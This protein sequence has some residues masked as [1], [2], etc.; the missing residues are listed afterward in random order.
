[1]S[2]SYTE[3]TSKN[4]FSRIAESIKGILF[5]VIVIPL[6]IFVLWWNE[7]RAVTT[8]K[9]LKEGAAAVVDVSPDQ[10]DPANDKK[11]VH[12]TGD[13]EAAEPVI[14][15]EFGISVPALRLVRSEEIFQWVEDTHTETKEKVGGSEETRTTYTYE[16]EW[17]D[18][19]VRSTK[20]KKPL[21][22]ENRGSLIAG[23]AN[24]S[25]EK[26]M[27]G[28]F[29]VPES[30]VREM[31][32]PTKH[33]VTDEDLKGL[34]ADLRDRAQIHAGT[35]YFGDDPDNPVIGD[36]RVSFQVVKPG[37]FSILAAQVGGTFGPYQTK[38]GDALTRVESGAVTAEV[39]FRNAESENT[40]MTW[41]ARL[42]GFLFMSF[43]F[44]AI[45][46]P[47]SVLGSVVPFIGS[48]IGMGTGLISFVLAGIISL[49]VIAI[50]WVVARPLLGIALLVLAVGGVIYMRKLAAASKAAA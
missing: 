38:A 26:V 12:V 20:F 28:A 31:G 40:F 43:G 32:D 17:T 48:I 1:M 46:R 24:I 8:A 14:N 35:F 25:A 42:L 10:I 45:M 39:M 2:D 44:M 4:W 27:L 37:T 13:A 18:E 16:K 29:R 11:L 19:P 50:A 49:V 33:P 22:H 3:V 5:G 7:G 23:D 15:R 36:V 30:L 21:G 9:S 6:T 47:L 41:L 34:P